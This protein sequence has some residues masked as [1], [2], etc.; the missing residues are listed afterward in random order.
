LELE[1]R[2]PTEEIRTTWFQVSDLNRE[3]EG[4]YPALKIESLPL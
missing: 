1:S 2:G 4:A 3:D